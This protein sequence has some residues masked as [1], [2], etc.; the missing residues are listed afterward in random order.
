MCHRGELHTTGYTYIGLRRYR[1]WSCISIA[2]GVFSLSLESQFSLGTTIV[3]GLL[4]ILNNSAKDVV[5]KDLVFDASASDHYATLRR[6]PTMFQGR[7]F[8]GVTALNI[9]PL[10]SGQAIHTE[11]GLE[12]YQWD[13]TGGGIG[14]LDDD[15]E[16]VGMAMSAVGNGRANV[17]ATYTIRPTDSVIITSVSSACPCSWY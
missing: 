5:I 6:N 11:I 10:D 14:S 12:V 17:A 15:G 2:M 8:S 3:S 7:A 4:L 1:W 13:G 16:V 9:Q